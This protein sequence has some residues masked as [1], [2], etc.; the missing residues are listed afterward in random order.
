MAAGCTCKTND[1][2]EAKK[3]ILNYIEELDIYGI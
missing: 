2:Q 1:I 3:M